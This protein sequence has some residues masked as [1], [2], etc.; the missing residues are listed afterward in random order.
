MSSIIP[1]YLICPITL[2]LM[3]DPVIC[4]DGITYNRKSIQK[5]L[6]TNNTSPKTNTI[7]KDIGLIPN[8]AL[9]K[10]VANFKRKDT[11]YL[12]VN[13]KRKTDVKVMCYSTYL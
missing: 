9:K 12:K 6:E 3:D 5:W 13:R 11:K 1:D 4:A 7:L 2:D 10:A 8:L